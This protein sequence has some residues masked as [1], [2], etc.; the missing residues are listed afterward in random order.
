MSPMDLPSRPTSSELGRQ[1][2]GKRGVEFW[3]TLEDIAARG[4]FRRILQAEM[5]REAAAW[6]GS[7]SRRK[8]LGLL[9]ASVALAGLSSCTK[10]PPEK[11]VPYIKQPEILIPGNPLYFASA[12]TIDGYAQGIIAT[13]QMGRP[14]KIEGNPDHPASLGGT[15][16]FMQASILTLYDPDRAQVIRHKGEI[17]TWN[18]FLDD[19][20]PELG[21]QKSVQGAGIRILS[22]T[23]TSPTLIDQVNRFQKMFPKARWH[24]FDPIS[25][26]SIREGSRIAF[27]RNLIPRYRFDRAGIV[28]AADSDF[29]S[30]GPGHLRYARDFA[31][32]RRVSESKLEMNR[33]Y[34]AEPSPTITGMMA[35]H[36]LP[37]NSE[38][39]ETVV[40]TVGE[41]LNIPGSSPASPIDDPAL[42]HWVSALV[43]DLQRHRGSGIVLAG[44]GQS[45][46]VHALIHAINEELGN[47]GTTVEYADDPVAAA[48]AGAGSLQELCSDIDSGTVDILLLLGGNP[49]YDAPADLD[50]AGR[51]RQ[52][53]LTIGLGLYED[54][55]AGLCTWHIP[56]SHYLEAWSD[57][58]AFDGTVTIM[59]PLIAPLYD[60]KSSHELIEE[61]TGHPDSAGYDIVTSYWKSRVADNAFDRFWQESLNA[62]FV[63]G[64]TIEPVG[65]RVDTRSERWR[66]GLAATPPSHNDGGL[67]FEFEPDSS[68][69]DGI[70]S[71]NAWLQELPKPV[72]KLTWDNAAL[73]GPATAGRL[74][75]RTED[76]VELR[77]KNRTTNAP[78]LIIPGQAEGV[79]TLHLGYGRTQAGHVG[80]GVGFDA[81]RLRTSDALWRSRGVEIRKTGDRLALAITQHHHEMEG[82]HQ[83]RVATLAD[84]VAHP[85]FAKDEA[86]DPAPDETLY[87]QHPDEGYAWGMSIDLNA[88]TG[89][90][91]CVIACQ[92]ENNIPVVGKEQVLNMREMHWIRIDSYF[93]GEPEQPTIFNQP[94]PCMHCENAPCELVCPVGATVHDSEGLNVM[95]YNRCIGT[96]Y[97]SNNCPYK[98]R[99]FNFFEYNDIQSPTL[100]MVENPDVTVRSRGVMEKCTYC[101][102][103]INAA[104]I[105]AEKADRPIGDGEIVTA[106]QAACPSKAIVF[107]DIND[108]RSRVSSL[109]AEPRNYGLLTELNTR[110][111]TTY[112][113]KLR[114]PNPDI[115]ERKLP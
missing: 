32:R 57:A 70:W 54:E 30:S 105:E 22:R 106:C 86:P 51:L 92:S 49:V 109:K 10:Q 101:L 47:S 73:I 76:V 58:R 39:I 31:D 6:D 29:L 59:Q 110:P 108:R 103:R 72:T 89:C 88:C 80:S 55:T 87:A 78:I 56:E 42:A 45:A 2:A 63:T 90:N 43:D 77:S 115:E 85:S 34:V 33:L 3:R 14:T 53:R 62:G 107:G 36:R 4:D 66:S 35:D 19:A 26:E 98:V 24:Q 69:G 60:S 114:N 37:L 7:L 100:K 83:V 68:I 15:D 102:Q 48:Q 95:V 67:E 25:W 84:Y 65:A 50:V 20:G 111:R 8:F 16:V 94:V 28:F 11:I 93:T 96:R 71:N 74:G 44:P 81:Y 113:A 12:M 23:V 61:L 18:K 99:R 38:M 64:T 82:R 17:S 9:G 27:G 97:C 104:R 52:V 91:A 21:I 75:L 46:A 13:S 79:V 112:L 5:P 1:L 41:K 40:R